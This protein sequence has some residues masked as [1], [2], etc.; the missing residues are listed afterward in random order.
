[1]DKEQLIRKLHDELQ[2][3]RGER[4]ASKRD[5]A[6]HSARMALKTYQSQRLARTHAAVLAAPDTHDAAEFFLEELYGAHDLS[7]RDADFER[8]IPTMQRMLSYESLHTITEAI[9]LDAL[10]ERL[11]T[12]MAVALGA[13]FSEGQYLE[14]Y[15]TVTTAPE[16]QR[17]LDLVQALGD[18][19]CKLVRIPLLSMTLRI[20]H[21]PARMAGLGDL[22]A[23]LANGFTTFKRMRR[24]NEFVDTIVARERQTAQNIYA[25]RPRP[26]EID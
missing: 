20:M 5:P 17:Q 13:H 1:M 22:Q 15:R 25:G 4:Q 12:A 24:P 2:S 16:R 18:S 26:F 6:L 11:D 23:F 7:Q 10:S 19:L 21:T 3:V 8:I 9:V 14:A